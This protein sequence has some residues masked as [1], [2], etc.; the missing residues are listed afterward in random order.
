M[1]KH[2]AAFASLALLASA[3]GTP[4]TTSE[5]TAAEQELIV[6]DTDTTAITEIDNTAV[7]IEK[8]SAEVDSL[9][10]EI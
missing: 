7:E 6:E 2:L 3:C 10:N 1:K 5:T 9:L 4:D 8:A